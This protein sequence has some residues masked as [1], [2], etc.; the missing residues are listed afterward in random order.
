ML[1]RSPCPLVSANPFFGPLTLFAAAGTSVNTF[2]DKAGPMCER[3]GANFRFADNP[4]IAPI[5][6]NR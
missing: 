3:R 5:N 2:G 4:T 6:A 1:P